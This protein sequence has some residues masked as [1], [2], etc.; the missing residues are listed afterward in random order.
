[1]RNLKNKDSENNI[2]EISS[3][4]NRLENEDVL[5]YYTILYKIPKYL[6]KVIY[7]F[8]FLVYILFK[9]NLI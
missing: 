2:I 5:K 4:G 9:F 1:M 6:E 8:L 7:Y 3:K